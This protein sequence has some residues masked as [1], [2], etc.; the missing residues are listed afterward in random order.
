MS[1]T[2]TQQ[3]FANFQA[4]NALVQSAFFA[5]PMPPAPA[6]LDSHAALAPLPSG[7]E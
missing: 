7:V 3:D 4:W 6:S 5:G 2:P 1:Y